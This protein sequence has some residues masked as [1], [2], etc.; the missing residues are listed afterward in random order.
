LVATNPGA[1]APLFALVFHNQTIDFLKPSPTPP[2]LYK[3][4]SCLLCRCLLLCC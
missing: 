3:L 2:V 1:P 4:K